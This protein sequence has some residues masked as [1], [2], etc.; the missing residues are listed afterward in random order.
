MPAR[1]AWNAQQ[2]WV[3]K[4]ESRT[5]S[6]WN[7]LQRSHHSDRSIHQKLT[8]QRPGIL[9]AL[10]QG[11]LSQSALQPGLQPS[12]RH[13]F[14]EESVGRLRITEGNGHRSTPV[15]NPRQK[16]RLGDGIKIGHPDGDGHPPGC[17][18]WQRA[19]AADQRTHSARPTH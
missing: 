8:A 17:G 3:L 14:V 19:P 16:N 13:R 2:S 6:K 5:P 10:F 4:R 18:E 11:Q 12:G 1:N 7:A 9:N 15:L